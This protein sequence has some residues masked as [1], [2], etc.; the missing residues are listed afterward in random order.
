MKEP[1]MSLFALPRR[2]TGDPRVDATLGRLYAETLRVD[3]DARAAASARG[4]DESSPAFYAAMKHAY[5]PVT[6]DLGATLYLLL[7]ATRP[8]VAVEFGTSLGIGALWMAAA[9]RDNGGGRLVATEFEPD[10]AAR[11]AAHLAEAGLA[12]QVEIRVGPA[13]H[14]LREATPDAVGLVLLDG[15]KSAYL[16]VLRVLEP[17]LA[18]G[19]LI[20]A[21]NTDMDGA[22][23]FLDHVDAPDSGYVRAAL[24]TAALGATHPFTLL[25]RAG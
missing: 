18:P 13:E 20:L 25:M 12:T 2:F 8:R 14:T 17:G 7:R 19:A 4:L 16:P 23:A 9:L 1:M 6:P 10:K 24:S 21:D 15:A 11:A 3:P 5:M 22:R